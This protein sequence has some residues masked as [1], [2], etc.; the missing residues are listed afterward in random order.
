MDRRTENPE[1]RAPLPNVSGPLS[2]P[3]RSSSPGPLPGHQAA[4]ALASSS[5]CPPFV[6]PAAGAGPSRALAQQSPYPL[7]CTQSVLHKRTGAG[8][9]PTSAVAGEFIPHLNT[10]AQRGQA[11]HLTSHS[12]GQVSPHPGPLDVK[13]SSVSPVQ[14][15]SV[16]EAGRPRGALAQLGRGRRGQRP[17]FRGAGGG[18]GALI[19]KSGAAAMAAASRAVGGLCPRPPARPSWPGPLPCPSPA[20]WA[21]WEPRVGTS[22][23]VAAQHGGAGAPRVREAGGDVGQMAALL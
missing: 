15:P 20:H 18:R 2:P 11:T 7:R 19:H 4:R 14:V 9:H 3:G 10:G 16:S 6:L 5:C 17:R 22:G 21:P 1:G 12:L 8:V 13:E 23:G